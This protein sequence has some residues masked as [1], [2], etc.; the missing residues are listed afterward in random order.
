MGKTLATIGGTVVHNIERLGEFFLLGYRALIWTFR[1]PFR[2]R[3]FLQSF[4][5]VGVGSLFIIALTGIFTGGVFALQSSYAFRMFNAESLVGATV[6]LAL[7]K[8]LAPVLTSLMVTGRV[9]SAMATEIGTMKVTEQIDAM[10][11]MAVNPIQYLVV[12]RVVAGLLMVPLL[13]VYFNFVGI[14]GAWLVGVELLGI[15]EGLFISKIK[16]YVKP[17]DLMSGVIKSAVFGMM[18]TMIG[19]YKGMNAAGGAKG[20]GIATTQSVV[21]GSVVTLILNYFLTV[22]MF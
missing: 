13:T 17:F 12:P 22:I 9:G 8:E 19:C 21:Y 20:V 16:W 14:F 11:T 7:T 18:I 3:L 2:W 10:V 6:A 4:N 5:F 15:D 1:P